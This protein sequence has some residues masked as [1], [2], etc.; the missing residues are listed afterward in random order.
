MDSCQ[1]QYG[2]SLWSLLDPSSREDD[3]GE[4][5]RSSLGQ[6]LVMPVGGLGTRMER[7]IPTWNLPLPKRETVVEFSSYH[8]IEEG[9][10]LLFLTPFKDI[11]VQRVLREKFDCNTCDDPAYRAGRGFALKSAAERGY[12]DG[13]DHIV[14]HNPDDIV[15][16]NQTAYR[17]YAPNTVTAITVAAV[18][19]PFTTFDTDRDHVVKA[20][21]RSSSIYS[22]THIGITVLEGK[23]IIE[24]CIKNLPSS[25]CDLEEEIFPM[26]VGQARLCTQ[27][28]DRIE[29]WY[30]IN[31]RKAYKNLCR[32]MEKD[33]QDVA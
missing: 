28:L 18:P 27:H 8:Y 23:E 2:K 4:R 9:Y 17:Y 1:D 22:P 7:D 24:S 32:L 10:S 16:G 15:L 33:G 25:P 14:V 31:D 13:F 11:Y 20:V 12:L 29:T 26:L 6:L 3:L 5:G 30:P 21:H 19:H